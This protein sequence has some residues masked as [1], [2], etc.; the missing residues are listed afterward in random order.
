MYENLCPSILS[1]LLVISNLVESFPQHCFAS[2]LLVQTNQA[3]ASDVVVLPLM[4]HSGVKMELFQE[5]QIN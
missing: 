1:L 4:P 2:T 3:L 5:L